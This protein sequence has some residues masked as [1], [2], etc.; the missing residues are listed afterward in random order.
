MFDVRVNL[1]YDWNANPWV[2]VI[3]FKRISKE[4]AAI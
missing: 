1:A 4:E 2:F 3:G